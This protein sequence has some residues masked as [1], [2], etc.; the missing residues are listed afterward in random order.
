MRTRR[1][2]FRKRKNNNRFWN[3]REKF[4]PSWMTMMTTM[5]KRMR[6]KKKRK[7]NWK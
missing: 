3:K 5:R 7:N 1:L 6:F 4:R 2:V